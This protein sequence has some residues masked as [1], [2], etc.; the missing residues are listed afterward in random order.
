MEKANL[1]LLRQTY[2]KS[3][4]SNIIHNISG[5]YIP[6]DFKWKNIGIAMSG[7]IDSTMLC[8]LL[9][10]LIEKNNLD[11]KIHVTSHVR[12]WKNRPWQRY[13]SENVYNWIRSRFP[14]I[15]MERYVGF[16]PPDL[17]WKD[18][19][20]TLIKN[21]Y[22]D[23]EYGDVL[24]MR[25]FAE[26]VGWHQKFDA[27]YNGTTLNPDDPNITL[28]LDVRNL[29]SNDI[30]EHFDYA[31]KYYRMG[32]HVLTCH[33]FRFVQKDWIVGRYKE[34]DIWDLFEMTRS[35]EGDRIE[36]PEIF[37]NLDFRNYKPDMEVP[38]C[39]KCFWCQEREWGIKNAY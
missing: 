5:V 2:E 8:Y 33:P 9:C 14:N 29:T 38:E 23:M 1:E 31:I 30:V 17:E 36:Y 21:E 35:C 26:F 16:I 27:Y 13:V 3:E 39:G 10:H 22:G 11:I 34:F 25:S 6:L 15:K 4:F 7:G 18:N 24:V 12:V 19:G 28:A 37:G 32:D 20:P